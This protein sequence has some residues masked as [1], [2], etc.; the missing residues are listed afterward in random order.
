M[1]D[2]SLDPLYPVLHH[3]LPT[4]HTP[5]YPYSPNE[6][7]HRR[8]TTTVQL[9]TLEAV[10]TIDT[11]PNANRRNE[12][13]AQLGMTARGVQVCPPAPSSSPSPTSYS[14]PTLSRFGSRIGI[15]PPFSPPSRSFVLT[16]IVDEQRRKIN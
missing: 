12:L 7:K 3:M 13:A 4:D 10:F 11:K 8:R 6:V 15:C 14:P 16:H 9:Q 1:F 5:F 2:P